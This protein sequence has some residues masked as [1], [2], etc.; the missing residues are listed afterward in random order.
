MK[1]VSAIAIFGLCLGWSAWAADTPSP[2][3]DGIVSPGEYAHSQKVLDGAGTLSYGLDAQ[4]L[5]VA[6]SVKT[7]GWIGVGLGSRRMNGATIFMGYVKDGKVVFSQ[8]KGSGH[9]H[10]P[11]NPALWDSR[12][13]VTQ[14]GF[15]TMEFH[16]P[17]A[18]LPWK[19]NSLPFI[20]AYSGSAD[21]T[22]Y[23]D[24]NDSGTL[25]LP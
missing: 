24:D 4:G 3:I 15:T 22:T 21:L 8:Q 20:A 18:Q 14:G 6:L 13:V 10:N 25:T 19:G 5:S 12:S 1:I 11:Q 16:I 23:H 7:S 2:S 9:T 17:A